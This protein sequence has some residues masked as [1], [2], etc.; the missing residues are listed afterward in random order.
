MQPPSTPPPARQPVSRRGFVASFLASFLVLPSFLRPG[1]GAQNGNPSPDLVPLATGLDLPGLFLCEHD[2]LALAWAA[3][4]RQGLILVGGLADPGVT[5]LALALANHRVQ[6]KPESILDLKDVEAGW[7]Q[8]MRTL[9]RSMP[10]L[11]LLGEIR[12][13]DDLESALC[14]AETGH[15]VIAGVQ[16]ADTAQM[17][18][19][20]TGV[21]APEDRPRYAAHLAECLVGVVCQRPAGQRTFYEVLVVTPELQVAIREDASYLRLRAIRQGQGVGRSLDEQMN[22]LAC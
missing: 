13:E 20:A 18:C 4:Q 7:N 17:L 8:R 21:A 22:D 16:A 15:L 12:C 10:A 9:M 14:A 3:G 6:G 2:G 19:L 1:K 11:I 5:D